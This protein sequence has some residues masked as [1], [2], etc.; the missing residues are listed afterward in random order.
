VACLGERHRSTVRTLTMLADIY[1]DEGTDDPAKLALAANTY[2]QVI[3]IQESNLGPD[4]SGLLPLLQ[5]Y[6]GL[7]QKLHE[8]T[9]AAEVKS[10]IAAISATQP[11]KQ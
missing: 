6:A 8:D 9:K 2:E 7:L 11:K 4:D 3:A 10:K 5:K 1:E